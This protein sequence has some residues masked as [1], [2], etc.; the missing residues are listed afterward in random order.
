MANTTPSWAQV[1]AFS[2]WVPSQGRTLSESGDAISITRRTA[3]G[4]WLSIS[5]NADGNYV[6]PLMVL[7]VFAS[8][9]D[10][11]NFAN[12]VAGAHGGWA[13]SSVYIGY[14]TPYE[15]S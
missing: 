3:N 5:K 13:D 11:A 15:A 9:S 7:L 12:S 2:G 8:V 10:A 14:G 6:I 1:S 4:L